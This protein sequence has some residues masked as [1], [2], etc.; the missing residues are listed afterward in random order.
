MGSGK[1]SPS[2]RDENQGVAV[3]EKGQKKKTESGS[4]GAQTRD[5]SKSFGH[6]ETTPKIN[7]EKGERRELRC[8]KS[9]N[10]WQVPL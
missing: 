8:A 7:M 3:G 1:Y 5:V 6:T 9:K 10:T 2:A 4:G